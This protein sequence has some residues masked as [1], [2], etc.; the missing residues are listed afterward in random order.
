M[1]YEIQHPGVRKLLEIFKEMP[2]RLAKKEREYYE[3]KRFVREVF[4]KAVEDALGIK[5]RNE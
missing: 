5:V 4:G 3:R 1:D 2:E